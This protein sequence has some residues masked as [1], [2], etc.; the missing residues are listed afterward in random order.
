MKQKRAKQ[1]IYQAF[2]LSSTTEEYHTCILQ[3]ARSNAMDL[4]LEERMPWNSS[5]FAKNR[6]LFV[7]MQKSSKK[8]FRAEIRLQE[9]L[10][11]SPES[12]CMGCGTMTKDNKMKECP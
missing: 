11:K 2:L 5:V 1:A 4:Y 8:A 3:C 9:K 7:E 10:R 6:D 12:N